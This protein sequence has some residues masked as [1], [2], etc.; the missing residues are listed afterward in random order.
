M[1]SGLKPPSA[2]ASWSLAKFSGSPTQIRPFTP[3]SFIDWTYGD[4]LTW[5][6]AG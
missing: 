3:L 5:P 2:I 6:A 1:K 4:Q